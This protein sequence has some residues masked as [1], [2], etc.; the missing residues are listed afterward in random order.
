MLA[1]YSPLLLVRPQRVLSGWS[2]MEGFRLGGCECSQ[3][4]IEVATD[5]W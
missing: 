4:A 2:G 3:E 1:L 5:D